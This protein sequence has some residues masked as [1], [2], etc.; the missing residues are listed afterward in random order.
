MNGSSPSDVAV[1][2]AGAVGVCTALNLV[3]SGKKVTIIDRDYP[4]SGTSMG[5]AGILNRGSIIPFN[6]PTLFKNL[7]KLVTKRQTGFDYKVRYLFNELN[8]GLKFIRHCNEADTRKRARALNSLI[9][10]SAQLYSQFNLNDILSHGGW[11]KLFR[12]NLPDND[13]FEIST[14]EENNVK[15]NRLNSEEIKNLE[16]AL[17]KY[18][19]NAL[20]IKE[21]AFLKD[22][23]KMVLTLF[24][25]YLEIDGH[26]IKQEISNVIKENGNWSVKLT[27]GQY[28]AAKH[29]VVALGPWSKDF[30]AKVNLILPMV[31]ERGAHREFSPGPIALTRPFHDTDGGYVLSPLEKRWR[32]TCGVELAPIEAPRS[33][34]QMNIACQAMQ[35]I[36]NCGERSAN[37]DWL[38][39][40]PTLP[41]SLPAIG[42]TKISNLWLATGHQHIG[43][44]TAPA[45]GELI[46]DLIS[47][48]T[49]AIDSSPFMP[50]RFNL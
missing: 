38:G 13:S 47:G 5:N 7:A 22:P 42:K 20:W 32:I 50:S 37:P 41:D 6:N 10:R 8:W 25:Q 43:M 31:F 45:T 36:I 40:R 44:A 26:F 28:I 2:G 14:L 23:Q 9:C 35:K 17:E 4:G 18:E 15:F 21:T 49:P 24:N 39:A 27:N 33:A 1:L 46:S 3:K 34:R 19:G 12:N 30:L 29:L 16:P 48:K 11:L